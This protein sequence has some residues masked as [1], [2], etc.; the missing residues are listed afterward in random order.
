LA[1]GPLELD[2]KVLKLYLTPGH[3]PGSLCIHWPERGILLTGDL[4]FARGF[5]RVD[6]AGGDPLALVDSIKRMAALDQVDIIV[7]GHG[8]SIV[9]RQQVLKNYE[10]IFA[11]FSLNG[12]M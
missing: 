5:G 7:P 9:G 4:I 3:S 12:F 11:S 10:A 2:D 8:P 6:L 1:E